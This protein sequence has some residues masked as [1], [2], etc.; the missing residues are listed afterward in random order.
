MSP[1]DFARLDALERRIATAW[2][3]AA[4]AWSEIKSAKLYRTTRE[5]KSQTWEQYCQRVHGITPQW[6]NKLISRATILQRLNAESETPLSLSPT[7]VGHLEG[8]PLQ[9]QAEIVKSV[10]KDGQ[11]ARAKDVAKAKATKQKRQEG[12]PTNGAGKTAG[13]QNEDAKSNPGNG[14]DSAGDQQ[15]ATGPGVGHETGEGL[16]EELEWIAQRL[17]EINQDE[18]GKI[19]WQSEA[20]KKGRRAVAALNKHAISIDRRFRNE[21]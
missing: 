9:E 6:A 13:D 14:S 10:T 5:G 12:T 1:G 16:V 7:A 15:D 11:A 2:D 21:E 3:E 19:H 4:L 8:L 20:V 17:S 18:F